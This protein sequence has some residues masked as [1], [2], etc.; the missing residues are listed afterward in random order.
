MFLEGHMDAF[1]L[2]AANPPALQRVRKSPSN[3]CRVPKSLKLRFAL[4]PL[5]YLAPTSLS[6]P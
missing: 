2:Q 3:S 4:S 5:P 1:I 6:R